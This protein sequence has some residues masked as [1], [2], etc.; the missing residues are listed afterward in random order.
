MGVRL[1]PIEKALAGKGESREVQYRRRMEAKG[2]KRVAVWVPNE[3]VADLQ[4]TAR[5]MLAE[6]GV[7]LGD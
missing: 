4:E 2:L 7:K 5:R 1:T 6:A 3:H